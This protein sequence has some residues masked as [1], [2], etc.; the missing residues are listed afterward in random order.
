MTVAPDPR[1]TAV[2][3][4]GTLKALIG[5]IAV[6]GQAHPSSGVGARALWKNAQKNEKKKHTSDRINRIIPNRRQER[7]SL[8]WSPLNVPSRIIS[9]HH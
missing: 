4:R 7:S 9:R 1:R 2:F 6:G 5:V 3:R 8:V